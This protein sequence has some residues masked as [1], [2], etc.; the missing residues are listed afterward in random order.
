MCSWNEDWDDVDFTTRASIKARQ[1]VAMTMTEE[2]TV[3]DPETKQPVPRDGETIGEIA[4]RSNTIMKGYLKNLDATA[5]SFDGG[6][7][8]SGDLAVMHPNGYIE[9]KDRLK[10]IIISGGE[11]ISS[12]EVENALH[13]HPEVA[14]A[15]VVA[16]PDEKWG[17]VP[18]A[19]VELKDGATVTA[20]ELMTFS[21]EH[22]PGFKI[23]KQVVFGEIPK[24]AT[25][26]LQKFEL[27]GKIKRGE[28]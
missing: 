23:P 27:R 9:V 4:L 10:D 20:E 2:A 17:E 6:Y 16:K 7:F 14:I 12:V 3:L 1:G 24:T 5:Q 8:S 21:R 15:A 18:C 13:R 22:L 19:F 25:G 11:N 26:K 28:V